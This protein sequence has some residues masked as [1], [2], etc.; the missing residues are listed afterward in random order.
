MKNIQSDVIL[1]FQ[2][3]IENMT[4]LG[5]E[6]ATLDAQ[7]GRLDQRIDAMR[8]SLSGLQSQVSR[9][10]DGNITESLTKGLNNFIAGNEIFLQQLGST[11]LTVQRETLQ[12][13]FGKIEVEI[14]EELRK[15]VRNMN[16]EIDSSYA[17]GQKLPISNEDF[18]EIN[19]E[20]AKVVKMQIHN[21]IKVI[22]NHTAS[23]T[24]PDSLEGLQV[25][26]GKN[27]IMAFVNKIKQEILNKLENPYVANSSDF[28]ITKEDLNKA[29]KNVKEKLLKSVEVEVPDVS[30]KEITDNIKNISNELERSF[31]EYVNK[32]VAGINGATAGKLDVPIQ[33]LSNKVKKIIAR[34][35][36][37]TVDQLDTLGT[38]D[39]G[40][41]RGNELKHQLE[42][43]AKALDKKM[44]NSVQEEIDQIVK[45]INNVEITPE[46]KLKRH[47][48]NQINHINNAMIDKIREQVDEQVQSIIQEINEVQSRPKGLNRDAK[49]QNAGGLDIS[50]ESYSENGKNDSTT[51]SETVSNGNS[52]S[53]ENSFAGTISNVAL[54]SAVSN[55]MRNKITG[56]MVGAPMLVLNQAVETFKSVQTEQI[57]MI[58]N[59]MMK[60]K[61]NKDENGNVL[62]STNMAGVENTVNELQSFIRQQSM[63]YGTD[64]HK[65]YQV[66]GVASGFLKEP[67]EMKEFVRVT[68]QLQALT[69]GSDPLKIAKGL[70]SAK[71]QFG[72]EM[73]DMEDRVAHPIA[74]V[75]QVT[76][77]SVEE[78][79]DIIK[80]SGSASN[81]TKVDSETAIVM[82]GASNQSP[83]IEGTNVSHFYNSIVERL[84]PSNLLN[85]MDKLAVDPNYGDDGE[86]VAAKLQ[87]PDAMKKLQELGLA[88][89]TDTGGQLLVPAKE[90]FKSISQK[91]SGADSLTVRNTADTLFGTSQ[92]SKG[93]AA[94]HEVMNT[95]VKVMQVTD[96]FNKS[97][98][99][100]MIMTSID[101]PLVNT[102]RATQGTTIAFDAIVQEMTPAINKVS[103]ALI[104]L[105]ENVAKNA[106]I[107]VALGD[108]LSNVVL[109]MLM[110]KGIKW[111]AG[112]LG[113]RSNFESETARTAFLDN[114]KD[115][116][117]DSDFKKLNRQEV[118][119]MQQDPLLNRYVQ[120]LNGMSEE[121]SRHFKDYISEKKVD[122][123]D[124]PTLFT[125]MDE[126]KNW[127]K[128]TEL[129]DDEKFDR[130]R[131]YNNRLGT[132]AELA[133][134]INPSLLTRLSNSTASQGTFGTYRANVSG[135]TELTD[136]MSR[137]SQGDFNGFED[138]LVD[139]QRN[140][141]PQINDIQ[142][143]S[144]A[145]DEYQNSQREIATS[146][147]RASPEFG[148]L[149]N[150]V[151]GMNSALSQTTS[152]KTG[153]K[154]FMKDISDMGR[155][156]ATSFRSFAGGIAK[157]ALEIS[158]AIVLAEAAKAIMWEASSTEDQRM[159]AM[160]DTDD[161]QLTSAANSIRIG[162]EGDGTSVAGFLN[163]L[164]GLYGDGMNL[165]Q[166]VANSDMS[167]AGVFTE[168]GSKEVAVGVLNMLN[169]DRGTNLRSLNDMYK[170]L[171]DNQDDPTLNETVLV[172][173][174]AKET[175]R[176]EDTKKLRQEAFTKQ[177]EASKLA[178][179]EQ[180][181]LKDIATKE[182]EK[183]YMEGAV[184][185]TSIDTDNVLNRVSDNLK[186]IKDTSQIETLRSLM[187]GM[188]TDSDEYMAMRKAQ[189]ASLRQVLD[190]ELAII[191]QYIQ[192]AKNIME[193]S[194]PESQEYQNA[195]NAYDS[196]TSA[197]GKVANEGEAEILQEKWNN[198]QETYQGQV[199]KVNNSLSRIDLLAQA[200]ELAAAYNMDTQSQEYLDTMKQIT[201]NKLSAMKS[202]LSNLKA[203]ESIG[204]LSEDQATQVLQLQN[205]IANEQA[206]IKE[207]NLASIGLGTAEIQNNNS[208]R[209]NRLLELKLRAGNPDDSSPILR[210]RRIAN[211]KEEVSEINQV[212]T[213][214]KA[215]LP[216]AGADETYK[217]NQEIRDLQKQSLQ[218]QLGILSEMKASAGTFNMPDGVQAMSRYQYLTRGNT[219]NTT[220]IGAGDVTVNIT[221]PNVTNGMTSS[222]LQ[223]VGQSIGQGLSVGRVGGLRNQ[224][225]MNP[226]NYRS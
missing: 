74:A 213:D 90:L 214:L 15:H 141:L 44:S 111:G 5:Q 13:I 108:V 68:A 122:I 99:E 101:N 212:I 183:K 35:L 154:Q 6:M 104:N 169:R 164:G 211:A 178:E 163:F 92:S 135:Y 87:S 123:K 124:I 149:S 81:N 148:N 26:V 63:F 221:L 65:L 11:G 8:T 9:G 175:G 218:T 60:D 105:A 61:Y 139:R 45:T 217:I 145:M 189:A 225:A 140:G 116:S 197:R 56:V 136:R 209:E 172:N 67:V 119:A 143:L 118:A 128:Q 201:L 177:Y 142:S 203:I 103:Y 132:R 120:E 20:V 185:L 176:I 168:G 102:K 200:K 134:V 64:Y 42:R 24:G 153:F 158:A 192:N 48:V 22:Q 150:A 57:K 144:R 96:N 196:F 115:V 10:T 167:H 53:Q 206:R 27:T 75:S 88:N 4:R 51:P 126:A 215:R 160:A 7:F 94:M 151:R 130:T 107:F 95:F 14:N 37:T 223:Q 80:R 161:K 159:M 85:K 133:G 41:F 156:A 83:A 174:W 194:D 49:I 157:A 138:H 47:L 3:S 91:L 179:I 171:N 25:T 210:N 50:T 84:Q 70:E 55:M 191:D 121:Q 46:P 31:T 78:L 226:I 182:Y 147:R 43:V 146:A 188:K 1:E 137:M 193:T 34:E 114:M 100:K 190:D 106:Q 205:Q 219:H 52:S 69:P 173:K 199:R 208:E 184:E 72:L 131:Q 16:V 40:S 39:L 33:N 71:S 127:E 30:G 23:L 186:E 180:K 224:Q 97:Q 21:L 18:N 216:A 202:E 28:I 82:A 17:K 77:T 109:G 2:K 155:G 117:V 110:L 222:Q 170:Y 165:I 59:L 207:Y 54:E 12:G 86:K 58:Q 93:A 62:N 66:G 181:E 36:E 220:A 195:K 98:Y 73:S 166:S 204:D 113:I 112:N 187:S 32:T 19:E 29:I 152:L 198:R 162:Q 76:N 129:T 79:F 125:T 38:V 89:V